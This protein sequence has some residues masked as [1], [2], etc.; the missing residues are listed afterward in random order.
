MFTPMCEIFPLI[1]LFA[2]NEIY[3]VEAMGSI[4]ILKICMIKP[5]VE[6]KSIL[7]FINM[8]KNHNLVR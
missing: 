1:P 5:K 2:Q 8:E 7:L 6:A 4:L 3:H